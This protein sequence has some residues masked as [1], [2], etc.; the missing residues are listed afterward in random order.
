[1]S[2]KDNNWKCRYVAGRD[3][4]LNDFLIPALKQAKRYY[5]VAGYFSSSVLSAAASGLAHF[6]DNG[7]KMELVVGAELE[8][9]DICAI[10]SG[11]TNSKEIIER[12]FINVLNNM[13]NAGL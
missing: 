1:M 8:K 13:E 3:N 10:N 4:P 6:I 11:L 2:F 5:R 9:D 7:E 12:Q